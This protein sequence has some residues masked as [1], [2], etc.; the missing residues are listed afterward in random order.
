M[1]RP[2]GTAVWTGARLED[3]DLESY[4]RSALILLCDLE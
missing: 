4:P 2:A 3:K 1:G